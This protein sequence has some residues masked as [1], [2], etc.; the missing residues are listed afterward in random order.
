M[1]HH[2]TTSDFTNYALTVAAARAVIKRIGLPAVV[3]PSFAL[4]G[5]GHDTITKEEEI[6]AKVTYG[7]QCSPTGEVL[8]ERVVLG[9][10]ANGTPTAEVPTV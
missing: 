9:W 3:R 7:L 5:A 8:I 1:T 6:E 10:D 4:A 2:H